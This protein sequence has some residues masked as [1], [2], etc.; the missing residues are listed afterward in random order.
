MIAALMNS[1]AGYNRWANAR[2][3]EA[4]LALP[5]I[6]YRR[7]VGIFFGSLHATLNHLLATDRI[8]LWRLTGEGD[9][10]DRLDAILHDDPVAL[11]RARIAEDARLVAVVAAL[12]AAALARPLV[13]RNMAG[14]SHEQPVAEIL[15]H[16]FNHQT[17][18]R[19]QAHSCLSILTRT[20]PPSLDLIQFQRGAP[21]P[22]LDAVIAALPRRA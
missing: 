22:D 10:P 14:R 9:A 8:W 7:D 17:H 11:A 13:Y 4:T 19:G 18:H 2:L 6:E 20:E 5:G 1:L 15:M 16:V 3:Y 12:D 21:A